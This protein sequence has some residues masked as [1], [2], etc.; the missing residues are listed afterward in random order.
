LIG[1]LLS[2]LQTL[3]TD[4]FIPHNDPTGEPELFDIT[5][6]EARTEIQPDT[7]ADD[8]CWEVVVFIAVG[9]NDGVHATIMAHRPGAV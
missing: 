9:W 2:E 3:L 4:R 6:A 1:V 8:L 5:L 7:M